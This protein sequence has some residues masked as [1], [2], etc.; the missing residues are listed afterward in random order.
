MRAVKRLDADG[1]LTPG[2]LLGV[3]FVQRARGDSTDAW[4]SDR[5]D[6]AIVR[7]ADNTTIVPGGARGAFTFFSAPLCTGGTAYFTGSPQPTVF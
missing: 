7:V 5:E 4:E 6:V 3:D 1:A 2:G